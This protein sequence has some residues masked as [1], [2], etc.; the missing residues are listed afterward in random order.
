VD[1]G[2]ERRL[3]K[4]VRDWDEAELLGLIEVGEQESLTLD[5]KASAGLAKDDVKKNDLSKDVSAFANSAGGVLIYGML[6]DRHVPTAIDVGL[7]RNVI[8]KE[9]LESVIKGVIQPVV[10][11]L[12]IRQIDVPSQGAGKVAYA[13]Q[14][15]SAT[16]R[17]PHQARDHRYYKRFNFESTPMEDYEVRDL[18]RRGIEYGKKYGAAWDLNVEINRLIAAIDKRRQIQSSDHL[19]RSSLVI[20]VSQALRSAG[21]ALV[22]LAKPLRNDVADLLKRIDEFNA[23]IETADPGQN[24]MARINDGRKADLAEMTEVGS[25]ISEALETILDV[26]L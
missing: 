12:V 26:E 11:G 24:Q 7:D 23:V 17:A 14:I 2:F 6:E 21:N 15:P 18:M 16:S 10:D 1:E 4:D 8:T 25:R 13:V 5:Y 20:A 19:P 9:W 3:M 22:L